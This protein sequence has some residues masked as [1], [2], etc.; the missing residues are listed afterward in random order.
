MKIGIDLDAV[1]ADMM[2]P[3]IDFHNKKYGTNFKIA[4]HITFS[5][6]KIWKC[7]EEEAIRRCFEFFQSDFLNQIK[8]VPGA[9]EG[10]NLL[11]NQHE[12]HVITSR[13]DLLNKHTSNWIEEYFPKKF[14][15]INHSNQFSKK[16]SIKRKK[17]NICKELKIDLMIEDHLEYALD[18]ASL[19]IK[20]LL[21]NMPWNQTKELPKNIIRVN[22]WK[23]II[24]IIS[25]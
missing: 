9:V 24:N 13:P 21:M 15:S 22:S 8:P 19:D 10:I 4:D 20:V 7:T 6:E 3:L 5:I 23:E 16:G 17:S 1:V 2:S 25:K 14:K 18:C 11:S 12:L